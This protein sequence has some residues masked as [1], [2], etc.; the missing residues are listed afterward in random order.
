[1]GVN[2]YTDADGG[3]VAIHRLDPRIEREQVERTRH[4]RASRDTAAAERALTA[5]AAAARGSDNLLFPLREALAAR[6][7][8]GEICDVL[9]RELGTFD[10]PDP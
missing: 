7:T 1:V 4:V 6:C 8:V 10:T 9:R 5:V 3:E 2:A